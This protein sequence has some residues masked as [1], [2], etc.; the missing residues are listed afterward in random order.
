MLDMDKKLKLLILSFVL[1]FS[2]GCATN[3]ITG[4][5]QLMLVSEGDDIAIG[6][7]YAPEV[8]KQ[9]GGRIRDKALQNYIDTVGRESFASA[10]GLIG[11]TISQ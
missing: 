7:E 1:C 2:A 3:P 4:E 8:E 9:L 5:E 11:N 6:C 10:T